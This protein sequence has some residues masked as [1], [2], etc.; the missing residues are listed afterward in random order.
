MSLT[1][2]DSI[3]LS[4]QAVKFCFYKSISAKLALIHTNFYYFYI[5][6]IFMDYSCN[7]SKP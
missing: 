4:S 2:R 6:F 3:H 1:A 5:I 7:S